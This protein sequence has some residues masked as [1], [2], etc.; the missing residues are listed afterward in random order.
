MNVFINLFICTN[1]HNIDLLWRDKHNM[2]C[3]GQMGCINMKLFDM[4]TTIYVS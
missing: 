4:C 2:L 1:K 3:I